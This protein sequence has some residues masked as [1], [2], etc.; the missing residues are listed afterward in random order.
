M[1]DEKDFKEDI[2]TWDDKKCITKLREL[3]QDER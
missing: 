2:D 3:L 1:T